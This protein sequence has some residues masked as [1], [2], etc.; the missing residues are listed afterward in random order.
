MKTFDVAVLGL[1][2]MGSAVL[3]RLA[4]R[5]LRALGVDRYH[6]PHAWGSSHGDT[7]ITRCA[8]GEGEHYTPLALRSHALWREIES[9]T[10]MQLLSPIGVLILS[11]AARTSFTHV[12]NFFANTVAAARQYRIDHEILDADAIRR[13]Y[14]QFRIRDDEVGYYEPGA[15]FLQPEA[16][17]A[18]Q[19]ELAR[20][21]GAEIHANERVTEFSQRQANVVITTDRDT[22][23]A[24]QLV[25]AAGSWLPEL[26]DAKL[27]RNFRVYRQVMYWF[28]DPAGA[29]RPDRFPVFIWELSGRKQ[30]IY[31]FPNLDGTG[32]KVATEQY[33]CPTTASGAGREVEAEESAAMHAAYVAPFLPGLSATCTRAAACLYTVTADF[34]FVIDRLR[35]SPRVIVASCCS[36]HGF[37]HTA[38]LGEAVAEMIV[39]GRSRIDLSRFAFARLSVC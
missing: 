11:G 22:Y 33:D 35:D 39:D 5:G 18:A 28:A 6:P 12:E 13:R 23:A 15:G 31:G 1:C 14:G 32:V 2:G 24:D 16:C 9:D 7:R 3:S 37:K 29:F 38:A 8:I 21:R 34:G 19:L 27:A 10:G 20:R 26:L 25:V 30:S 36:G 17:I 4:A